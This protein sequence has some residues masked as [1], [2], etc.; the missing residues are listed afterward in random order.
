[1][2]EFKFFFNDRILF[3]PKVIA[4]VTTDSSVPTVEFASRLEK[5]ILDKLPWETYTKSSL[6]WLSKKDNKLVV[7]VCLIP[8]KGITREQSVKDLE[9]ANFVRDTTF[10]GQ[11]ITES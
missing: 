8:Q 9:A 3:D 11:A 4:F 2:E 5:A 6:P 7:C 10:D 1:M